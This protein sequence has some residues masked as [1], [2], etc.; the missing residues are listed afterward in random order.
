MNLKHG[1]RYLFSIAL[2]FSILLLSACRDTREY[3][4]PDASIRQIG[5]IIRDFAGLNGFYITYINED[6]NRSAFRIYIGTTYTTLPS[7]TE[8]T[9]RNQAFRNTDILRR[10][11][12]TDIDTFRSSVGS[13][14]SSSR[15]SETVATDWSVAIQLSRSSGGVNV[16]L[17]S[18]GGYNPSKYAKDFIRLLKHNGFSIEKKKS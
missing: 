13:V 11:N 1:L 6:F 2:V 18:S 12:A 3:Y 5:D 16:L 7:Q 10:D 14:R 4:I 17:Q 15:P 9:F 8:T